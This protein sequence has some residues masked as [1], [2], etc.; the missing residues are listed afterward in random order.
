[1]RARLLATAAVITL[2]VPVFAVGASAAPNQQACFG[3]ARAANSSTAG[4]TDTSTGKLVSVRAQ[5]GTNA[6]Q[7]SDFKTAC[8]G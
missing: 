4:G 3:Q 8:Q 7:N 1:M 5:E 6:Q 2:S